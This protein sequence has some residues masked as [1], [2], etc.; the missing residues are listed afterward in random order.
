MNHGLWNRRLA[1][2]HRRDGG[3][4]T[5]FSAGGLSS[6]RGI[7]IRRRC[8]I[9]LLITAAC[10]VVFIW[11][12]AGSWNEVYL[13]AGNARLSFQRGGVA[14]WWDVQSLPM[15][16]YTVTPVGPYFQAPLWVEHT[17]GGVRGLLVPYWSILLPILAACGWL[18]RPRP[19]PA[20]FACLACG[21]DLRGNQSGTCPE[22]GAVIPDERL[23][24][25]DAEQGGGA[26][27]P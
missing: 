21:Y 1:C 20:A 15:T 5:I 24:P 25:T 3:A 23:V 17:R 12:L 2:I 19:K 13:R 8:L 10:A 16:G 14:V 22:C 7:Y 11:L 18:M 27:V 6:K 26:T 4:T 9:I